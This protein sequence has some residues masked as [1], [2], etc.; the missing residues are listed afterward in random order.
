LDPGGPENL[1]GSQPVSHP[2][3]PEGSTDRVNNK[4]PVP[5]AIGNVVGDHKGMVMEKY[6]PMKIMQ[7]KEPGKKEPRTPERI[8]NP[9]IQVIIRLGRRVIGNYRRTLIIIIVVNNLRGRSRRVIIC[10]LSGLFLGGP[11]GRLRLNRLPNHFDSIPVFL[12]NGFIPVGEMHD[13]VFIDIFINDGTGSPSAGGRLTPRWQSG[14][15]SDT[16]TKLGLQIP[17]CLQSRLLSHP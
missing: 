1:L 17:Y 3:S 9:R 10:L 11:H 16:Q 4:H 15:R 8:R 12:G 13:P 5:N 7:D 6:M 14:T 2:A